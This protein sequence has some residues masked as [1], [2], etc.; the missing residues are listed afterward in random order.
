MFFFF[1][2]RFFFEFFQHGTINK[3]RL[4]II[5]IFNGV[6]SL[7]DKNKNMIAKVHITKNMMFP[8]F[9][10]E[11]TSFSLKTTKKYGNWL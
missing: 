5:H 3:K 10:Q 2:L 9:F 6:Y 11:K 7:N 8:M 1:F 4:H